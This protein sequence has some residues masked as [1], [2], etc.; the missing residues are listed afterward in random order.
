MFLTL[1]SRLA[2]MFS[3]LNQFKVG[4]IVVDPQNVAAPPSQL[5]NKDY[6]PDHMLA[7]KRQMLML[8]TAFPGKDHLIFIERVNPITFFILHVE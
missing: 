6:Y 8:G 5:A 3:H 7:L 2:T 4:D 1:C